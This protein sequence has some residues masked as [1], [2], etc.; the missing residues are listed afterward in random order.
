[1]R[2]NGAC[3]GRPV[4]G[5]S[6]CSER[7]RS[8]P[9]RWRVKM[10]HGPITLG[11]PFAR[12]VRCLLLT[13]RCDRR[14]SSRER[15]ND[16]G[17]H[18]RRGVER[19][20]PLCAQRAVYVRCAFE[21]EGRHVGRVDRA[22][23]LPWRTVRV[24]DVAAAAPRTGKRSWTRPES[25]TKP[26]CEGLSQGASMGSRK[27]VSRCRAVLS[28]GD[29]PNPLWFR[30]VAG[31]WRGS[32]SADLGHLVSPPECVER[33]QFLRRVEPQQDLHRTTPKPQIN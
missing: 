25:G 26:A 2:A 6:S 5:A 19:A 18:S 22:A 16:Q 29:R 15:L 17:G 12:A 8:R 4:A 11:G 1:M 28:G 20:P 10:V 33:R 7:V 23:C 13:R 24:L 30:G 32:I 14:S 27:L 21:R 9:T 3:H 31:G